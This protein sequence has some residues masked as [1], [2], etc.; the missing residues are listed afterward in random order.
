MCKSVSISVCVNAC[1]CVYVKVIIYECEY[2]STC[3]LACANACVCIHAH[4]NVREGV[5]IFASDN[6][7]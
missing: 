6:I 2:V 3:V 4:E 7:S 5:C 1:E